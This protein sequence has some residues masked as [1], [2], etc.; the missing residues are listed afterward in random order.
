[1]NQHVLPEYSVGEEIANAVTHGVGAILA[2]VGL[3][4]MTAFAALHGDAFHVTA[5]AIF[6]AALVLCYT[7]STL[8]HGI[9]IERAKRVLRALDHSAIFLLIAGTYTPFMLVNLR[10]PWGWSLLSVIWA[11]AVGGIALRLVLRGRRH[12]VVVAFYVAMGWVVVV[13]VQPMLERVATGGLLLLAGGGLAYT[14]GV[15]FYKWRR[16]PYNHAIWHGFV[17]LG[18]AL[19]FFAVLFYVIPWP[20]T[21]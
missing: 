9:P 19:H 11:L 1:M 21:T 15:V 5:C 17:L 18:S 3:A 14:G 2:I 8:Y 13:A 12:G 4:V 6:G 10:G 16:L 7:A 20:A